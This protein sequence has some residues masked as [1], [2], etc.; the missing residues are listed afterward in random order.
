MPEEVS[1]GSHVIVRR[2]EPGDYDALQR[3]FSGPRAV[4]GTMQMPLP[5]VE[6][7][8]RRLAEPPE[9]LFSLVACAD[10]EVVGSLSLEASIRWRMRHGATLWMVVRDDWQGKGVGTAHMDAALDLADNWLNLTR[11]ELRVY[12][13]NAPAIALYKKF[14]FEIEGTH[15][16]MARVVNR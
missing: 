9:G 10:G 1:R 15:R 13:D 6:M 3:I 5:S 8:R 16:R 11:V 2:T 4:A 7:W 12:V 14:G